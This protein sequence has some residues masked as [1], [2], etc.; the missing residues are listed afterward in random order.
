M[1]MWVPFFLPKN[2]SMSIGRGWMRRLLCVALVI[3]YFCLVYIYKYICLNYTQW[4]KR[5]SFYLAR[6][7]NSLFLS[8][9]S[10]SSFLL[11]LSSVF[12]SEDAHRRG[13]WC[14]PQQ[15]MADSC[16][17]LLLQRLER[18]RLFFTWQTLLRLSS[19]E[20]IFLSCIWFFR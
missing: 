14:L 8:P 12:P 9:S 16:L 18:S 2:S 11:I 3:F 20:E 6:L 19:W 5:I 10:F 17:P 1:T 13:M 7:Y 4:P 15:Q